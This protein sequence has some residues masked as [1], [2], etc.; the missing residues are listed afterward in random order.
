MS[1][2]DWQS[3]WQAMIAAV[4]RDF[5][6]G[7]IRWGADP[8][9][10]GAIRRWLEPLEF[11]CELHT[12]AEVARAHGYP[13]VVAPVAST[14]VWAVPPMRQPGEAIFVSDDRDAQPA[15]SPIN[16]VGLA[17]APPTTGFFATDME[18]DFLAPVVVGTRLARRGNR[19]LACRPKQT[20]VGRGAFLKWE[21]DVVD[22]DL[23]VIARVRT[24][25]YAYNPHREDP[26][27]G[28]DGR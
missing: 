10:R 8:V 24:G 9:E 1:E 20:A 19:L 27:A 15:R 16:N 5:D 23:N 21:T 4:G 13:D 12:D 14:L 28:E 6:E 22:Q 2:D 25:T 11:D 18:L 3:G 17:L 26:G 7:P